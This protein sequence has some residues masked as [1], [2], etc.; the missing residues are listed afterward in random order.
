M[1]KQ[2]TG[3]QLE[4]YDAMRKKVMAVRRKML[5]KRRE[6]EQSQ[7]GRMN[8]LPALVLPKRPPNR[9]YIMSHTDPWKAYR[10]YMSLMKDSL[11]ATMEVRYN[12]FFAFREMLESQAGIHFE[13]GRITKE[14]MDK[15]TDDDIR[16]IAEVYQK[17]FNRAYGHGGLEK[18]LDMYERGY[19]VQLRWIYD[20]IQGST[21][22]GTFS[23]EQLELIELYKQTTFKGKVSDLGTSSAYKRERLGKGWGNA[24]THK[25][26]RKK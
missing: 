24:K 6:I 14:E 8:A 5:R 4:L 19:I 3:K 26:F 15:I 20:E 22:A 13:K 1:A 9:L 11:S 17:L 25:R 16:R 21:L 10:K 7:G 23:L 12:Y 2:L 18:F